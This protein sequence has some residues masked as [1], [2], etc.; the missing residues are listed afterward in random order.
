M[1][2]KTAHSV[3]STVHRMGTKALDRRQ[4]ARREDLAEELL[5]ILEELLAN[6]STYLEL[7][8]EDVIQRARM[9]RSTFYRYFEDKNDLLRAVSAS[10][11]ENIVTAAFEPWDLPSGATRE[12]RRAGM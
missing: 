10:A 3:P 12:E 1:F 2:H 8:V 7:R 4:A 11:L 6:G 9:G 5:P